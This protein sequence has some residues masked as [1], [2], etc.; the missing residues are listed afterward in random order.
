MALKKILRYAWMT[1]AVVT[2]LGFATVYLSAGYIP[3]RAKVS[4]GLNLAGGAKARLV[5]IYQDTGRFPTNNVD[6]G[7]PPPDSISGLYVSQ[8]EVLPGGKIAV[9]YGGS[10]PDRQIAGR[11]LLVETIEPDMDGVFQWTCSSASLEQRHLPSACRSEGAPQHRSVIFYLHG[12]IIEDAGPQPVHPRWGM[13]DYPAVV[14][15]LGG[16]GA[17][18]V[19]EQRA[20][21]TDVSDYAK[22]VVADIER[23]LAAEFPAQNIGVVGFSKGGGIAINASS[24]LQDADIRYV[25]LAACSEEIGSVPKLAPSGRVLSVIEESDNLMGT[26]NDLV[27]R[28]PNLGDYR[29]ITISTGKEHGAFYLPRSEWVEPVLDWVHAPQEEPRE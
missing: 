5:E 23:L 10:D 13:Y 26:C 2:A 19:S 16:R 14:A 4:E 22:Q 12:R 11:V 27:S 15:A 28:N 29:E 9:T 8:V 1:A 25:F 20:S 21:D 18:M 6:A 17:A 3:T 24:L 7:L